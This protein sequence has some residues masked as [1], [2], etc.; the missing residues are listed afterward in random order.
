LAQSQLFLD[1]AVT[2]VAISASPIARDLTPAQFWAKRGPRRDQWR[3]PGS[4]R[5]R[6]H[7]Q[8][9]RPLGPPGPPQR[10]PDS[11]FIQGYTKCNIEFKNRY[12]DIQVLRRGYD[13]CVRQ[14]D[15]DRLRPPFQPDQRPRHR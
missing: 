3:R 7:Y 1:L 5:R 2:R 12:G 15:L 13:S 14:M 9:P 8:R 10:L 11:Y 6:R 4:E